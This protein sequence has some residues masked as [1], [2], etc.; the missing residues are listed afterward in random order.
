MDAALKTAMEST[1]HDPETYAHHREGLVCWLE[2]VLRGAGI[3]QA[4]IKL[5]THEAH[6]PPYYHSSTAILVVMPDPA[7]P[8]FPGEMVSRTSF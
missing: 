7:V 6:V 5:S 4:Y 3:N 8:N 2:C 1:T